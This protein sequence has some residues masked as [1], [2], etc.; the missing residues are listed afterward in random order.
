MV[1]QSI[2]CIKTKPQHSDLHIVEV[3]C[4]WSHLYLHQV[5]INS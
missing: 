1:A 2:F 3:F 4:W 5:I